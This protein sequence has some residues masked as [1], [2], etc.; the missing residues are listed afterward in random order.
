MSIKHVLMSLSWNSILFPLHKDLLPNL[1]Y[2]SKVFHGRITLQGNTNYINAKSRFVTGSLHLRFIWSSF[3]HIKAFL[4]SLINAIKSKERTTIT[5]LNVDIFMKA[6]PVNTCEKIDL[7]IVS[8]I[9]ILYYSSMYWK[10][11]K[12]QFEI[13]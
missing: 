13:F 4:L 6:K 10:Q 2:F 11:T 12:N 5:L 8:S 1:I 3:R 7:K 9:L